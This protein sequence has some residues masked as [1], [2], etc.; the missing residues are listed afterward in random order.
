MYRAKRDAEKEILINYLAKAKREARKEI[1]SF[2][3]LERSER[4]TK[5]GST[6]WLDEFFN[7]YLLLGPLLRLLFK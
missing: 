2:D 1:M 3:P 6:D 5:E 4:L 7:L